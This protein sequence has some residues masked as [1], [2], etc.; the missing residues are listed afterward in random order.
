VL[1][2]FVIDGLMCHVDVLAWAIFLADFRLT[3]KNLVVRRPISAA[4]ESTANL[5]YDPCA[6]VE[7]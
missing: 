2:T 1:C 6:T 5:L 7:R 4:Q 3:L